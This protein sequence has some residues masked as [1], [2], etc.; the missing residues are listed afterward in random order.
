MPKTTSSKQRQ[1][2]TGCLFCIQCAIGRKGWRLQRLWPSGQQ[3]KGHNS[4]AFFWL[5]RWQ[6]RWVAT[7][8]LWRLETASRSRGH[9]CWASTFPGLSYSTSSLSKANMW[10]NLGEQCLRV[11]CTW[12]STMGPRLKQKFI[13]VHF[14]SVLHTKKV[15]SLNS[16]N[17]L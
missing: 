6:C 9:F 7:T 15:E 17:Q 1:A 13:K 2:G 5:R 3:D 12:Q 10:H 16:G 11:H 14:Y 4:Q 8:H